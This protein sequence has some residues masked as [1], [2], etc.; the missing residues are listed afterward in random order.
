MPHLRDLCPVTSTVWP[1]P[2]PARPSVAFMET[3]GPLIPLALLPCFVCVLRLLGPWTA[4]CG[5]LLSSLKVSVGEGPR[6]HT[7]GGQ[8][9][10]RFPWVDLYCSPPAFGPRHAAIMAPCVAWTAGDLRRG[11]L[12]PGHRRRPPRP[13]RGPSSA[14]REPRAEAGVE[15]PVSGRARPLGFLLS[16][17]GN[18]KASEKRC[19]MFGV[20]VSLASC[21]RALWTGTGRPADSDT[22][23]QGTGPFSRPQISGSAASFSVRAAVFLPVPF[24]PHHPPRPRGLSGVLSYFL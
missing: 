22:G 9:A 6:S 8:P 14:V 21:K 3:K 2:R 13:R 7:H 16:S 20:T 23:P 15:P 10:A 11:R 19:R 4:A 17:S 5:R 12:G 24:R 18:K 1:Q